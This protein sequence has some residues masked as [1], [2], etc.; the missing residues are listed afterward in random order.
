[1]IRTARLFAVGLA[2]LAM[3]P[4]AP[5][6]EPPPVPVNRAEVKQTLERS[7]HSQPRLPLPP[8]TDEEKAAAAKA[9]QGQRSGLGGGIVNNG[10]MQRYY[11][12]AALR[13]NPTRPAPTKPGEQPRYGTDPAQPLDNNFRVMFFWLTSRLN[14]CYYCLGHQEVKLQ[15]GGVPEDRIAALDGDWSEFNPAERAAFAFVRKLGRAPQDVGA[16]DIDALRKHYNDRQVL[17]IV[18]STAGFNMINRWTLGLNI[19]QE[20]HRVFLT[21]TADRYRKLISAV[22]PID[23]AAVG[24]SA[25]CRAR[26]NDRGPLESRGEVEAKFAASRNRTPRLP[27][28]DEAQARALLPADAKDGT[29]PQYVRL[30]AHFPEAGKSRVASLYAARDKGQLDRTLRARISW[31]AARQDRAWYA[32]GH[33]QKRLRELG[34]ADDAI[35]ALDGPEEDLKPA[36][37]AVVHL[38]KTLTTDPALVTDA[39]VAAVRAHFSDRETAEVVYFITL[40]A[41]FDRLTEPAAL[42]L[43]S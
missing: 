35:F 7:K 38:A 21:P 9:P 10:R 19:P 12:D 11:I 8:L 36:D 15:A 22:A 42:P 39:D 4:P 43:E 28:V 26:A 33:A 31:V 32:L 27:L 17:D 16:A 25:L 24:S 1:M 41:F 6:D 2:T 23:P 29:V 18:F 3:A 30:L 34:Q 5:A 37:R 13:G 20:D 14:N 40:A